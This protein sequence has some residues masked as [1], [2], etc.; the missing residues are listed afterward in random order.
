MRHLHRQLVR[1]FKLVNDL[2]EDL[3][4]I[5]ASLSLSCKHTSGTIPFDASF[6]SKNCTKHHPSLYSSIMR[7]A[8]PMLMCSSSGRLGVKRATTFISRGLSVSC[9]K[10]EKL[11][12][13]LSEFIPKVDDTGV[14]RG[15]RTKSLGA[16]DT[17]RAGVTTEIPSTSG[18][19]EDCR[20]V[21]DF[22]EAYD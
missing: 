7:T 6:L 12:W 2:F 3:C 4:P 5:A 1:Q 14:G 8:S 18:M 15:G 17:V 9:S 11:I 20:D 21:F 13:L 10:L 22:T 19:V 16:N